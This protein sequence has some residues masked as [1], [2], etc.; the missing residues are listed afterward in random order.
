MCQH[1]CSANYRADFFSY[2]PFGYPAQNGAYI[3][4]CCGGAFD[5]KSITIDHIVPQASPLAVALRNVHCIEN[6]QPMCRS[7]NSSK[8][9]HMSMTDMMR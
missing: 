7:C 1:G 6:L 8:N 3:C 9:K 2:Y 4:V 5:Q